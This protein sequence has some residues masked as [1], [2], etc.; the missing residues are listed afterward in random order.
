MG[1]LLMF[2]V[3][4]WIS[5]DSH[6]ETFRVAYY[7]GGD[8]P[9]S[10]T[11]NG[12]LI[13]IFPDLMA[14]IARQSGDQLENQAL[15]MK[16][17]LNAFESGLLDIEVGVNPKWRSTS[18]TPGAYSDA[19]L[20]VNDVLCYRVGKRKKN[21]NI[22]NFLG[23]TIG[24]IANYSYPEFDAAFAKGSIKRA[25]IFTNTSLLVMLKAMRFDQII[26]SQYVK[27][28]WAKTDP[29]KYNCE[30]GRVVESRSIMLRVHPT[31][32]YAVMRFNAAINTL[33]KN[34]ELD[35]ILRRYIN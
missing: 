26:I 19:F 12:Q 5:I 6:A 31:K 3:A 17:L 28:Y 11:L 4:M 13:G 27:Q 35:A 10:Y 20:L 33:K 7:D 22:S 8:A 1:K 30:E 32:A 16:R 2:L 9:F 25:D 18:L 23:E 24:V 29:D 21:E 15:P 14:A 34:G